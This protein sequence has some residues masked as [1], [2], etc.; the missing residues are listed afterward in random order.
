MRCLGVTIKNKTCKNRIR[1]T[2]RFCNVHNNQN[3]YIVYDKL[4]DDIV[5]NIALF[6]GN[7]TEFESDILL[8]IICCFIFGILFWFIFKG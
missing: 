4:N 5:R 2:N 3:I 7:E 6:V 8:F 1:K